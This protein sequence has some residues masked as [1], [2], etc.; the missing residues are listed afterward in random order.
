[1]KVDIQ[2]LSSVKKKISVL[3]P[4]EKVEEGLKNELANIA[5][6]VQI[7]GFRKG[8]APLSM[9]EKY[10]MPEAMERFV[11]KTVKESL[12]KIVE[13]HNLDLATTPVLESQNLSEEGFAFE[14]TLELHPKIELKSYKGLTF[15]KEKVE[16]T[17]EEI[18]SQLEELRKRNRELIA[19]GENEVI[20]DGD[21]VEILVEKYTIAGEVKGENFQEH[22]D[23]TLPDIYPEIRSTLINSK[24]GEKKTVV[25]SIK[26]REGG[27][28]KEKEME[29]IFE[30]KGIKKYLNPSDEKLLN[31]FNCASVDELKEKVKSD[32]LKKKQLE[33]ERR[34]R[35]EV[36]DVLSAENPFE[37]PPT[38]IRNLAEKMAE[39]MFSQYRRYGINP[40][41]AGFDW[42]GVVKSFIP[43]AERSLKQQY[44]IK[45]IKEA[46]NIDVSEEELENKLEEL[47]GSIPENEKAK[48]FNNFNLRN[49]LYVDMISK[50]VYDF[51]LENNNVVEE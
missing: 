3:F 47:F 6:V 41:E 17:E 46:E 22:V 43:D 7:K 23:L 48:Y 4:K 24:V 45:A 2:D 10:Y 9:V 36:F 50:K 20:E 37:V 26:E 40:E 51:L 16:V 33:A 14:L 11:D 44:L 35:R 15:K 13:E 34:L 21:V 27:E 18:N 25:V 30:I 39:D 19:K 38:S 1:M 49:N 29:I 8:K 42:E 28:E 5:K 32:L 12:K 31:L